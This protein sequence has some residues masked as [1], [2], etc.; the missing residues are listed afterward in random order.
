MSTGI[1]YVFY[2]LQRAYGDCTLANGIVRV[3]ARAPD[4]RP[5]P[6]VTLRVVTNAAPPRGLIRAIISALRVRQWVKNG[7]VVIAPA[8]A[9]KV[10]RGADMSH[11]LIA[12]F[13][14]SLVASCVYVLNDLRDVHDD[15]SHPTKRYRAIAAG[16]LSPAT[17]MIVGIVSGAIGL[18]LPLI[19]S[20]PGWYFLILALYIGESLAYIAGVKRLPVIELVFVASGFFLRALAG[21]AASHIAVSEWFLVVIFF[22]ALFLVVGKR[23]AEKRNVGEAN[24]AVL[25]EYTAEFLHSALTMTATVVVTAYSLWAFDRSATGLSSV[26]HHVV[27]IQLS[28]IPVVV[29]VL[30]I[31]RGAE[32][33]E[34]EAPEDLLL[35]NRQVQILVVIWA[36]LLAVGVYA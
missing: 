2:Y 11:T 25:K 30:S 23:A 3:P 24:R 20:L 16:Q 31:M 33:P 15:R 17:A 29:A 9:G 6:R 7:L 12:F 5:T 26:R 13:S 34:G 8:A 27:P 22:G 21:A 4:G 35:R 10:F 28:I 18:G 1:F 32:S 36:A 19:A 14:F